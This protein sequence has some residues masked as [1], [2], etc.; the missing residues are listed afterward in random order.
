MKTSNPGSQLLAVA[1]E[2]Y[3]AVETYYVLVLFCGS[4]LTAAGIL[5][6]NKFGM[7]Q[8]SKALEHNS[9]LP[10]TYSDATVEIVTDTA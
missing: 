1:N 3:A 6:V 7:K 2:R 8:P 9:E 4:C 5:P 10:Q